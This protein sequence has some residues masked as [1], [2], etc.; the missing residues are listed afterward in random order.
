M[1]V[2]HALNGQ[3]FLPAWTAA[4]VG[5]EAFC[6]P[7]FLMEGPLSREVDSPHLR[8]MRAGWLERE[9]SIPAAR[10]LEGLEAQDAFLARAAEADEVVLWFEED[11]FCQVHLLYLVGRFVAPDLKDI[12]LSLCLADWPGG[13]GAMGAADLGGLYEARRPVEGDARTA[14]HAAWYAYAGP[15]PAEAVAL[16]DGRA[17]EPARAALVNHLLT[18]PGEGSG[19]SV[20]EEELL[21][22][23]ARGP[24]S[25]RDAFE[26]V[27]AGEESRRLGLGDL[28]VWWTIRKMSSGAKPLLDVAGPGPLP[29]FGDA[30]P[31]DWEAWR[32]GLAAAGEACLSGAHDA[33]ADPGWERWLGGTRL[34]G[35]EPAWRRRGDRLEP[36]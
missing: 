30:A 6:W 36:V 32:I 14:G 29:M 15:R 7:D 10:Y 27:R 1:T 24:V 2:L 21:R 33:A 20:A 17:W 16:V 31:K 8:R 11:L 34:R 4:D 13:L 3:A 35:P 12:P 26:A 28:Q 9:Y 25:P 5:G 22:A 19:L 18:F 23:A